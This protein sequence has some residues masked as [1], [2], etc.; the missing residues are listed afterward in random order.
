LSGVSLGRSAETLLRPIFLSRGHRG[1]TG[2]DF[3]ADAW[4]V[5]APGLAGVARMLRPP[6]HSRNRFNQLLG[7]FFGEAL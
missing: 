6:H 2:L 5:H 7:A 4:L 1:N 3:P